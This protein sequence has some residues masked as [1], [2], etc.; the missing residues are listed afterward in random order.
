MKQIELVNQYNI[1]AL[2]DDED[3]DKV[4]QFR[5]RL[6]KGRYAIGGVR[7]FRMHRMILSCDVGE[8]IDHINGNGLD[9]R[10]QNLRVVKHRQNSA[11]RKASS[12]NLLGYKGVTKAGNG[13]TARIRVNYKQ[14]Y[15]GYYNSTVAAAKAY[16]KAAKEHFGEYAKL[17]FP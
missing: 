7:S 13:W 9:N 8:E 10:K 6:E 2:V 15:I 12:S 5:W 11:N 14:I 3:F 17:N 4:S 16:D 1:F